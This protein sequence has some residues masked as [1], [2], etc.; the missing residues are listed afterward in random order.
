M[1]FFNLTIELYY[2]LLH[3][4]N[5]TMDIMIPQYFL[6]RL[7]SPACYFPV[8]S[9]TNL[10]VLLN[11][12]EPMEAISANHTYGMVKRSTF[13]SHSIYETLAQA[14]CSTIGIIKGIGG[15]VYAMKRPCPH[16]E[17]CL[18][19]CNSLHLRM[20]DPPTTHLSWSAIGAVHVYGRRPS[21]V[22]STP[23]LK[24]FWIADYEYHT[25]CGP[26]FCCCSVC[27]PTQ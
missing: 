15:W 23:G 21:S 17:S 27:L 3:N 24:V 18:Q 2:W 13:T 5:H 20:L 7:P 10:S 6:Y 12:Q 8:L 14:A 9:I 16:H 25:G 4:T 1:H 26:N 22:A 11:L 19:I